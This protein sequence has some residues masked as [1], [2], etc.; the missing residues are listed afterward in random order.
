MSQEPDFG[1]LIAER[2]QSKVYFLMTV[3]VAGIGAALLLGA[4]SLLIRGYPR[5]RKQ[6]ITML[7]L[8]PAFLAAGFFMYRHYR[9]KFEFR[10]FGAIAR[11]YG[12]I[13]RSIAYAEC[14]RLLYSVTRQYVNGI[15]AGTT[16]TLG[17]K[18]QGRPT[19]SWSGAHK[20]KPVGLSYTILGKG[21]FKGEDELDVVKLVIADAMA[22]KWIDRLAA[23][24]KINW[25]GQLELAADTVTIL[26]GKRKKQTVAYADLD[27]F[28][29]KDGW[30]HLFH[31][32][33]ERSCVTLSMNGENFWPGMRVM[34]RMWEVTLEETASDADGQVPPQG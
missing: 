8:S 25:L 9:T 6:G 3:L 21:E 1:K 23:G 18:A 17:L 32:G 30:M 12:A 13:V 29:L 34:E 33:D 7:L 24:E 16:V 28:S 20:Q 14:E 19:V 15:Y 31:Q 4:M 2:G 27:R 26:R 10:E 11:R 22:D 5:D